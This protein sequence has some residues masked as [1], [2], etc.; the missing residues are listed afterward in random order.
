METEKT[1][2]ISPVFIPRNRKE[3]RAFLREREKLRSGLLVDVVSKFIDD[4]FDESINSE[5]TDIYRF[6]LDQFQNRCSIIER[7]ITP[8]YWKINRHY[9]EQ[10]AKPIEKEYA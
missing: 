3:V 5:Y 8:K 4:V 2:L 9:F 6:H 10:I 1:Y 7:L